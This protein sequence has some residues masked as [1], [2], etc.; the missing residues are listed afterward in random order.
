MSKTLAKLF[1]EESAEKA[2]DIRLKKILQSHLEGFPETLTNGEKRFKDIENAKTKAHLIKWKTLENIDR[3]L[4]DFERNFQNKGGQVIWANTAEE[5]RNEILKILKDRNFKKTVKSKSNVLE[6]IKIRSFL[7]NRDYEVIESDMGD[8]LVS[9][10]NQSYSH[11][12]HSAMHLS[13]EDVKPAFSEVEEK[14]INDKPHLLSEFSTSIRKDSKAAEVLLSGA[15]FL[16][17]DSGSVAISENEGNIRLVSSQCSLHIVVAGIEKVLPKMEDLDLFWPLLSTHSTGQPLTSYNSL[18]NGPRKVYETEGPGE[19]ILVLLDNGRSQLLEKEEQREALYCI[20]CGACLN[21]SSVYKTIGGHAYNTDYVG[22]IGSI[23]MPH[24]K[25]M[26]NYKHLSF[27]STLCGECHKACPAKIDIDRLLLLNRRDA[28]RENMQTPAEYKGWKYYLR[29]FKNR[30]FLDFFQGK[31]KNKIL[32]LFS[33]KIWSNKGDQPVFAPKSF[34]QQW[35]EKRQE[36]EKNK[37]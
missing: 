1:R 24:L 11:R 4:L 36:E 22:P 26:N 31:M 16:I 34:A 13:M 27:A 9:A 32:N 7:K 33:K 3:H 25:G 35:K 37:N 8:H 10:T 20:G 29:I 21:V 28:V 18:F 15:N 23:V 17:S 14:K 12:I 19:M 5:A 30:K 2:Q 6:E